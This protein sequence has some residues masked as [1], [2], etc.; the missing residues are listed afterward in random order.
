MKK[1]L[2][3]SLLLVSAGMLL[4][5]GGTYFVYVA[6][7]ANYDNIPNESPTKL[8]SSGIEK[9]V[10]ISAETINEQHPRS[11]VDSQSA[12]TLDDPSLQSNSFQR[13]LAVYSYVAGL[14]T[15]QVL[16]ELQLTIGTSSKH[17]GR[18]LQE[19]QT[20]L[21]ERLAILDPTAAMNFAIEQRALGEESSALNSWNLHRYIAQGNGSTVLPF[22]RNVFKEWALSDR[23]GAVKQAKTLK[24]E[25]KSNALAGILK[26]LTGESLST[27][28]TIARELGDEDQ[29]I[30]SYVMSFNSR[31]VDDP[32]AVWDEIV[33]LIKPGSHNHLPALENVARQWYQQVGMSM[34]DE[35]NSDSLD[36][37]SKARVVQV[38]LWLA[39]KENPDQ[40]FRYA[41]SIPRQGIYSQPL[42]NVVNT[43][44]ESDPQA[45]Y[46]AVTEIEQSGLRENLQRSVVSVWAMNEPYYFLENV[47]DFPP[48]IRDLGSSRA[49]ESIARTSPQEAAEI[50][51]NH[52]AGTVGGLTYVPTQIMQH[53]V[54]LDV[55]GAVNWVI[56]GPVSEE[57]SFTWVS[58]LANNLVRSDPRR[59][60][61]LALEQP[62]KEGMVGMYMPAL[63]AQIIGQIV[64][65]D[66]DLAVELLPKVREGR[67]R[68]QAYS[69][70]GN[71]YL[72][73]GQ[74]SKAVDLGQKLSADEQV[75]YFQSIAFTWARVD[76]SGLIE[77][78]KSLPTAELRSNLA[79]SLS[80]QWMR[81]N[82]TDSQLDILQQFI[83]D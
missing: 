11:S 40:A 45:A 17:S 1:S 14:P 24:A 13:K 59:A 15:Q 19:L 30:E 21:V 76:P 8:D 77:S 81:E 35:V 23:D 5:G 27:Y 41:L 32:K 71:G 16:N 75:S 12:T 66:F 7:T 44:S 82:F 55:E 18:V 42:Y 6:T 20:A 64:I 4:G 36:E 46:Q 65:Q 49:L 33:T 54:K 9:T 73:L 51:L 57:Q 10:P 69:S 53:W 79:H 38:V 61:E 50:C 67:S 26:T 28:R 62:I 68:T 43:W 47:E 80:S 83:N 37:A 78:F 63:E 29:G 25:E 22:V 60:F 58:A 3:S 52:K 74:S 34:L 31:Q 56:N 48:Q 72:N 39:S 70:V 2:A